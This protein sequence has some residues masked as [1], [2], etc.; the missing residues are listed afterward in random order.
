[1]VLIWSLYGPY[2]VLIWSLYGPYKES[3]TYKTTAYL[4]YSRTHNLQN[5]SFFKVSVSLSVSL[6]LSV[7]VSVLL[8]L[9]RT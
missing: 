3:T 7:S 2:M 4:R 6:S 9:L 8:E 5:S 1:M